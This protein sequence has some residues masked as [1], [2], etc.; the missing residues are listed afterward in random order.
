MPTPAPAPLW[1]RLAALLY[2]LFP[3]IGLWMLVAA[4]TLAAAPGDID[5]A[6]PSSWYQLALRSALLLVTA[7][8]FVLSWT[9]GGQTIGMRAWRIRVVAEDGASLPWPRAV[10]RF[11]V[12]LV[13]L[14]ACGLGFAWCLIDRERRAWHDLAA[15]SR[16][17][18][19]A[20]A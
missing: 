16:V 13:S 11:G 15:R 18:R 12:A 1:Q 3:L 8:Y 2:D 4:A 10:L 7:G 20:M 14:A 6:H 17:S 5:V 19:I 9:R